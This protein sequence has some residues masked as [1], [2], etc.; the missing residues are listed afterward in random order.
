MSFSNLLDTLLEYLLYVITILF[1]VLLVALLGLCIYGAVLNEANHINEGIVVD[2]DYD[3]AYTTISTIYNGKSTVTMPQYHSESYQ[4]Q[5][6]GEKEGEIVT[7]W[8]TVSE[9][10]YHSVE[11]GEYFPPEEESHE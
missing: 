4:I 9:Q 1:V 2:K 11:I 7:Y 3:P 8:K 6:C 5:L 10:E